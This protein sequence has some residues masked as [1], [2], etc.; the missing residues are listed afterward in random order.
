[1]K[2]GYKLT[3]NRDAHALVLTTSPA[4]RECQ[5]W[6]AVPDISHWATQ[7][8]SCSLPLYRV[9][10][11]DKQSWAAISSVFELFWPAERIQNSA[12]SYTACLVQALPLIF[13]WHGAWLVGCLWPLTAW[14]WPSAG[15]RFCLKSCAL[16]SEGHVS[17]FKV[18]FSCKQYT[19][20]Q[21]QLHV[22]DNYL[23]R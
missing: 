6:Q 7:C 17:M 22:P 9:W 16:K 21:K 5:G 15:F 18:S 3:G 1:M 19:V 11:E 10:A 23:R 8:C 12:A 4:G 20:P 14:I 13:M 2:L